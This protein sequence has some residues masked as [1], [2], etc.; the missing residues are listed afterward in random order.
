MGGLSFL[1]FDFLTLKC[2]EANYLL[3]VI[4]WSIFPIVICLI[5]FILYSFRLSKLQA[6]SIWQSFGGDKS[7]PT[8]SAA[9]RRFK[10]DRSLILLRQHMSFFILWSY[11]VV[12]PVARKQL[13][14]MDCVEVAGKQYVR[15]ETRVSCES[16]R[17]QL[18]LLLLL[19]IVLFYTIIIIIIII[20]I[21][22]LKM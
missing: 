2:F 20:S 11:L 1:S 19:S 9:M 22:V 15:V 17:C 10:R 8:L 21:T 13:E 4:L 16:P 5:N 7:D 18:L 14:A 6:A 3:S 12:P